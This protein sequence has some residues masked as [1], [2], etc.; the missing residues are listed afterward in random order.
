MSIFVDLES[1]PPEYRATEPNHSFCS[2]PYPGVID[3]PVSLAERKHILHLHNYER[4]LV[5]GTNME[6]MVTNFI[7]FEEGGSDMES[8]LSIGMM[9]LRELLFDMRVHASLIMTEPA[10]EASQVGCGRS[11][12]E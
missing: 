10:N 2:Q 6:K 1:C 9:T 11:V 7:G 12:I 4:Q 3:L 8:L 5:R